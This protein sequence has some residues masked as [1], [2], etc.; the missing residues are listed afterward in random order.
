MVDGTQLM[1]SRIE[2]AKIILKPYNFLK[3]IHFFVHGY[4]EYSEQ[5]KDS[6]S[7]GEWPN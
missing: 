4:P 2:K 7:I 5:V 1:E 3:I 6:D